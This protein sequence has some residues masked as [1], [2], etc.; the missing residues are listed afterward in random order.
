MLVGGAN[1]NAK[2]MFEE[3][4][5]CRKDI[6]GYAISYRSDYKTNIHFEIEKKEFYVNDGK[7]FDMRTLKAINQQCKELGWIE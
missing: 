2:E 3:L 5:Y 4:G 1:L 6:K 7:T